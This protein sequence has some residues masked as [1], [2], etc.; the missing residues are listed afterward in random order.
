MKASGRGY[1]Y[2]AP[3]FVKRWEVEGEIATAYERW[4]LAGAAPLI[5]PF[6]DYGGRIEDQSPIR[7]TMPERFLCEKLA[8]RMTVLADGTVPLCELDFEQAYTAGSAWDTP[9]PELWRGK[10]LEDL[11]AAH[12]E[13]RFD[14]C[15]LCAAC[16]DWD[17]L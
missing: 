16:K 13:G 15:A 1:P 3:E 12:R 6:V 5:R 11:R 10:R 2:A 14:A 9:L 7:L 8:H 17:Y 4:W